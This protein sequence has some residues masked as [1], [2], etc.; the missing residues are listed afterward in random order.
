MGNRS[1]PVPRGQV[2]ARLLQIGLFSLE[3]L[4]CPQFGNPMPCPGSPRGG[5]SLPVKAAASREWGVGQ[6][7]QDQHFCLLP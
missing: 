7:S 4:A 6:P 5:R 3:M 2:R 1:T